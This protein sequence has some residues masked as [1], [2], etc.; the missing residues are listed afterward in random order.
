[1]IFEIASKYFAFRLPDTFF[2]PCS[3]RWYV[4]AAAN[5]YTKAITIGNPIFSPS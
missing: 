2:Q 3:S 1:L 4:S 5:G